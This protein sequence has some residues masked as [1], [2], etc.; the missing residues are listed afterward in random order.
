[1][2]AERRVS[3]YSG[4]LRRRLD[5]AVSLVGDPPVLF[6]DEPTTG[7]DPRARRTLWE[8]VA[9]LANAGTCVLLCTQYLDEADHLAQRIAVLD[10]GR[11]IAEGTPDELKARVGGGTLRLRPADPARSTDVRAIVGDVARATPD[12]PGRGVVSAPVADDAALG[13]AVRRLE[14]A[15]IAVIE[16]SLRLPSLDEVFFALTHHEDRLAVAA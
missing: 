2:W 3:T 9:G 7:L 5:L 1:M 10:R 4:G 11:V 14:D 6:L 12:S 16:L 13:A 8:I 15:G